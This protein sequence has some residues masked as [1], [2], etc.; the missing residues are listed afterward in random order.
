MNCASCITEMLLSLVLLLRDSVWFIT[1]QLS[2]FHC[3]MSKYFVLVWANP[4]S[5]NEICFDQIAVFDWTGE[6]IWITKA[7]AATLPDCNLNRY[8]IIAVLSA[9]RWIILKNYWNTCNWLDSL[10]HVFYILLFG[11]F[12][13]RRHVLYQ[14]PGETERA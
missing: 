12:L 14:D 9:F 11:L 7:P 13:K 2:S 3:C 1:V 8:F 5:L 6:F 10:L 4:K